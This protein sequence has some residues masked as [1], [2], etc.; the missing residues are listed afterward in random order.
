MNDRTI[1]ALCSAAMAGMVFLS[2]VM[3]GMFS[4]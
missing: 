2:F 3:H 1:D 4:Q